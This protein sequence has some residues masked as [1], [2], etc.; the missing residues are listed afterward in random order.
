MKKIAL[1]SILLFALAAGMALAQDTIVVRDTVLVSAADTMIV[2]IEDDDEDDCDCVGIWLTV[3]L[4][5]IGILTLLVIVI[6]LPFT[7]QWLRFSATAES[8]LKEMDRCL[9]R[10][11]VIE[12]DI[13][14]IRKRIRGLENK[15]PGEMTEEEKKGLDM[16]EREI[17]KIPPSELTAEDWYY[18]GINHLSQL[19]L[20]SAIYFFSKA[21]E[22][23]PDYIEAYYSRAVAKITLDK[24]EDS[25]KDFSKV[26]ELEFRIALAY[27]LRGDAKSITGDKA[28]DQEER[29]KWYEEAIEDYKEALRLNPEYEFVKYKLARAEEVLAELDEEPDETESK[30]EDN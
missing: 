6:S 13:E 8:K 9:E 23:K 28:K 10:A 25:I 21:I 29:R 14:K 1:T 17:S 5:V 24:H 12:T 2:E 26:I 15:E 3:I 4:V 18:R 27:S 7:V 20:Y 16:F 22:L 11:K 30:P 19:K